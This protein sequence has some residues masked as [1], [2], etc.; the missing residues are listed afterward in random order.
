MGLNVNFEN[1][2]TVKEVDSPLCN[3]Y[4]YDIFISGRFTVLGVVEVY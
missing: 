4:K 3:Q 2:Y 1:E